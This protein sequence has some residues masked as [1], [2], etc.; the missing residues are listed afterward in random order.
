MADAG[1]PIQSDPLPPAPCAKSIFA[2]HGVPLARPITVPLAQESFLAPTDP[3]LAHEILLP[4]SSRLAAL[5]DVGA[6]ML[7]VVV[8]ETAAQLTLVLLVGFGIPAVGEN[9]PEIDLARQMVERAQRIPGLICAAFATFAAIG[10][11]LAFRRQSPRSVGV[12][13][14]GLALDCVIGIGAVIALYLVSMSATLAVYVLAPELLDEMGKNAERLVELI[15]NIGLLQFAGVAMVV[16]IYE[17]VL[18]RGFLMTRLRRVTGSWTL[19][20]LISTVLFTVLHAFDQV[21]VALPM[22]AFLSLAFSVVTIWRRSIVP[23]VI[24]HGLF[25]LS[26]FLILDLQMGESWT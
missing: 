22:I 5:A 24:A 2:L 11:I 23:A 18:F 9:G 19:A 8:L 3:V 14:P 25:D 12:R 10:I 21:W 1:E 6:L 4:G 15:P 7:M 20:V 13:R 16:G 17:E 26:Q